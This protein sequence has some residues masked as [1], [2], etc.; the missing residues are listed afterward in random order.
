M[1]RRQLLG[2]LPVAGLAACAGRRV[3]APSSRGPLLWLAQRGS[4]RVY[5]LGV[6]EATGH[7]WQSAAIERG[8]TASGHLWLETAPPPRDTEAKARYDALIAQL[9]YRAGRGF[10]DTLEPAVRD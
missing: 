7:S 6:A 10:Y 1:R 2:S 4:A 9:G 5:V 8:F 3:P